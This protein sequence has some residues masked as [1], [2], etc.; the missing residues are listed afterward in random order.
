MQLAPSYGF[1]AVSDV[2]ASDLFSVLPDCVHHSFYFRKGFL[3]F[4][5][6]PFKGFLS[7]FV[8]FVR[9]SYP[10]FS[11]SFRSFLP[12][13]SLPYSWGCRVKLAN[14]IARPGSFLFH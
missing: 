8:G 4:F 14:A 7:F 13:G 9:G 1:T 5:Q 10:F 3:T 2:K 11:A 6:K 12:Q